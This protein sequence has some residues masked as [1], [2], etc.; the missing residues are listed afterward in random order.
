MLI[1]TFNSDTINYLVRITCLIVSKTENKTLLMICLAIQH[2]H[3]ILDYSKLKQ[4][5]N[6]HQKPTSRGKRKNTGWKG[7]WK[8]K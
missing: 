5:Q 4:Q 8:G 6:Q 3:Y 2:H 1:H 7:S